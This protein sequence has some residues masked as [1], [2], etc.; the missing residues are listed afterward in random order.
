MK[1]VI[2]HAERMLDGHDSREDNYELWKT[3]YEFM[4]GETALVFERA[5]NDGKYVFCG[6]VD[7]EKNRELFYLIEQD[8]LIGR[9]IEDRKSFDEAWESGEYELDGIILLDSKVFAE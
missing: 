7:R 6:L 9:Y 4:N 3:I 2:L 1:K 8:G 5:A